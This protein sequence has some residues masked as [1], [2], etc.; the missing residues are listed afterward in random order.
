MLINIWRYAKIIKLYNYKIIQLYNYFYRGYYDFIL[1][2]GLAQ[3]IPQIGYIPEILQGSFCITL[4]IAGLL[5][6]KNGIIVLLITFI[7]KHSGIGPEIG[8]EICVAFIA[9][10]TSDASWFALKQL[11]IFTR[12]SSSVEYILQLAEAAFSGFDPSSLD[13]D[14]EQPSTDP[15]ILRIGPK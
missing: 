6:C 11:L 14:S 8:N 2:E 1:G 12:S 13:G 4:A 15:N 10:G 9:P 5:D 7:S 3:F